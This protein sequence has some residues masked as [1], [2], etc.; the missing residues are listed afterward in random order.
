M[1]VVAKQ[2]FRRI[3]GAVGVNAMVALA[4]AA[5]FLLA[6]ELSLL[7]KFLGGQNIDPYLLKLK[8]LALWVL[9]AYPKIR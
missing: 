9:R 3:P 6:Y 4:S 5:V 8:L 1:R 7:I 2:F